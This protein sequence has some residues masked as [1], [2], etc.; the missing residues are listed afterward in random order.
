MLGPSSPAAAFSRTFVRHTTHARSVLPHSVLVL[1][2]NSVAL[3]AYLSLHA[4]AHFRMTS[5]LCAPS[6]GY[7]FIPSACWVCTKRPFGEEYHGLLT[8]FW[9]FGTNLLM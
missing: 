6:R 7:T 9:A 8:R 1:L 2:Q 3:P 4:L 5:R